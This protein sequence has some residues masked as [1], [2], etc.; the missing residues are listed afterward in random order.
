MEFLVLLNLKLNLPSITI[1]NLTERTTVLRTVTNAGQADAVYR[2]VQSPP[3][4]KMSVEPSIIIF[5]K[6]Q[7]KQSFK[8][9]F[10]TSHMVQGSYLL[11]SL[12]WYDG[13]AHYVRI[14]VAVRPV[15]SDNYADV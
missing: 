11:G 12:A 5:S 15:L 2:V 3:G 7:K 13:G 9:T 8:V 14:P 4:I 1:P 6:D 10:S